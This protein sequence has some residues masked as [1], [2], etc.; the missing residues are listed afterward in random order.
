MFRSSLTVERLVPAGIEISKRSLGYTRAAVIVNTSDAF[1]SSNNR[2]VMGA[3]ARHTD[4]S[5]VSTI[6]Y[7]RP[8]T[9]AT[10]PDLATELSE[11]KAAEPDAIFIS[12]LP[13]DRIGVML[14]LHA[15]GIT[16]VPT[17]TSLLSN[18]D[19]AQVIQQNPAAAEGAVAFHV[20][21]ASSAQ[22][23]SRDF[24]AN[25]RAASGKEPSDYVARG[26]AAAFVLARAIADSENHES[27]AVQQALAKTRGLDTIFGSFAFD[28]HGDA[29]YDPVVAQVR[30][31]SFVTLQ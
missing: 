1:S 12:G 30:N 21:M 20:W 15:A 5:V 7:E 6:E 26:Y 31:G 23:L 22:P 16:G 10:V 27:S 19:I 2:T 14:Q 8:Q 11:L 29:V 18:S 13:A 24:V 9:D 28:E 17:L 3:L 4:V 25:Y